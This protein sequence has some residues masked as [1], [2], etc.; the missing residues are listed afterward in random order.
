MQPTLLLNATYEPLMIIGWQRA[1]ILVVLGKSDVL[2]EYTRSVHSVRLDIRLP[3]VLRLRQRVRRCDPQ[4]RFSRAAIYRRD[5]HR[6]QY[7]G[8]HFPARAL[9]YDHV[10]PR[11]RG[12]Q[13]VWTNIVT[14]CVPCNRRKADKNLRESGMRLLTTPHRPRWRVSIG[15]ALGIGLPDSWGFY[16]GVL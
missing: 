13:T 2:E 10:H 9:T 14:C 15:D 12:G 1:I 4:V 6:C 16:L 8:R 7:C 3:S 11:S 5:E